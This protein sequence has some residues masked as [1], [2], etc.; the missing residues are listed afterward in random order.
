[1][2]E[3]A[4]NVYEMQIRVRPGPGCNMP[5]DAVGGE[6]LC[7]VGAAD[8]M[9]ALRLAVEELNSRGFEF[10]DLVG[11]TVGQI[12]PEKWDENAQDLCRSLASRFCG[13][14]ESV[15][16]SLPDAAGIR[17]LIENGG[18]RL[19]SF[20]CWDTEPPPGPEEEQDGPELSDEEIDRHNEIYNAGYG[21]IK[22]VLFAEGPFQP[23][24]EAARDRLRQAIH[25]FEQALDI[26]PSNWQAMLLMGKTFQGLGEHEQALAAFLRAHECEPEHIM[27]AVE[28]GAAAG[29]LGQ[30]DLAVRVMEPVAR[31]HPEDPR[32]PINLGLSYL[33]LGDFPAARAAF[34][35]AI[36]L[37]P[38]RAT[39]RRLLEL[40]DDVESGKCPCP[41]NEAEVVKAIQGQVGFPPGG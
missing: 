32:L 10:E 20:F 7:F 11:K 18:F 16:A 36:H 13:S 25:C 30:H 4:N 26:V 1:M 3:P 38:D 33:F 15:L 14:E 39:N 34:E 27:V 21:L 17:Q 22:D 29:R 2:K 9:T 41:A 37:E 40:L 28:T 19:G 35:Q 23:P 31:Q 5:P 12:I 24:D 8:H 6:A